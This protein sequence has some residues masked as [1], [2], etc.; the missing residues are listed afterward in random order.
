MAKVNS[1]P[2]K[3]ENTAKLSNQKKRKRYQPGSL[4]RSDRI[5]NLPSG[6]QEIQ[7][8]VEAITVIESDNEDEEHTSVGD[9]VPELNN[10][11][12]EEEQPEP[13]LNNKSVEEKIDYIAQLLES[14]QNVKVKEECFP[15]GSPNMTYKSLY[16]DAQN[17]IKALTNENHELSLKLEVALAKLEVYE[18]GS[19]VFSE[20]ME[21]MKDVIVMSSLMKATET[22]VN[23]S[24]EA[25]R[26]ALSAQGVVRKPETSAKKNKKK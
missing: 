9:E 26:K 12:V 1:N 3:A 21:K 15:S 4:R 5:M 10:A 16:V 19:S 23:I 13:A 17:K 14:Q 11:N 8:V 25:I 20:L 7:P 22:A 6:N 18:K 24:S 2:S